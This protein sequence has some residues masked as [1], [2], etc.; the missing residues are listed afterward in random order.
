MQYMVQQ[1]AMKEQTY[2]RSPDAL[3][4]EDIRGFQRRILDYYRRHG[5]DLPWRATT[6]PYRILV[7][8]IMLQQTQVD[9]VLPKYLAFM[10]SFPDPAALA[11]ATLQQVLALWSGLGY[12]RRAKALKNCAEAVMA[13]HGGRLPET[14]EALM[15]LPGIGPYTARAVCAFAYNRPETVLET[16]I[17]SVYIHFFFAGQTAVRDGDLVPFIEKTLY[18]PNPRRW[19]NGLMDYGVML[20]KTRGNPSRKSSGH[21]R[22]SSFQGS[23]RQV[24]GMIIKILL[25]H[26]GCTEAALIQKTGRDPARV[27]AALAELLAEGLI[28]KKGVKIGLP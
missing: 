4:P 8:E 17:R 18:R 6:D 10:E 14:H 16:N 19:Y 25:P 11:G 15:K 12:N 3:S 1:S 9:R 26:A 2:P 21:V 23:N 13:H 7:S 22:Q 24:R 27:R 5:R 28:I 20:K